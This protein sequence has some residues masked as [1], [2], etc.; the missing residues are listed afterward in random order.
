MRGLHSGQICPSGA[1][2]GSSGEM[3][4]VEKWYTLYLIYTLTL[5]SRVLVF[6]HVSSYDCN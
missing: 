6:R 2:G 5:F 3:E 1:V 4:K